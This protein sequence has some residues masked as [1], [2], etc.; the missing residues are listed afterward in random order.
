MWSA[1]LHTWPSSVVLP[2]LPPIQALWKPRQCGKGPDIIYRTSQN[3]NINNFREFR[4]WSTFAN[5]IIRKLLSSH[6]LGILDYVYYYNYDDVTYDGGR[7]RKLFV[8]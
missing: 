3:V 4:E 6:I 7:P 8:W 5:I 1:G 2:A